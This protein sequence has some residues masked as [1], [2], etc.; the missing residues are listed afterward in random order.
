MVFPL[1]IPVALLG[2]ALSRNLVERDTKKTIKSRK[3]K[4]KK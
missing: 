3:N 2:L 1:L 4:G